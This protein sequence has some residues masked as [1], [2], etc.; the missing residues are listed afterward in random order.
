MMRPGFQ[1]LR[2]D[3][4]L[5]SAQVLAQVAKF[6]RL[7]VTVHYQRAPPLQEPDGGKGHTW[8]LWRE[9]LCALH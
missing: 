7:S 6:L 9:M 2:D 4:L 5:R 1:K 8:E 3:D